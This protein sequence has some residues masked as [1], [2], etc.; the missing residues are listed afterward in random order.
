MNKMRGCNEFKG[1]ERGIEMLYSKE[2]T[3][4]NC[5]NLIASTG[6][7]IGAAVAPR[8]AASA[9]ILSVPIQPT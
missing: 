1:K 7:M 9:G 3:I 2:Q 4:G 6:G 5:E 8:L